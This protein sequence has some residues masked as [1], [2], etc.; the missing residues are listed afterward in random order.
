MN[1]SS[2]HLLSDIH[3][4]NGEISDRIFCLKGSRS[5]GPNIN[6]MISCKNQALDS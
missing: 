1:R 5:S 2:F 3:S 6:L 4:F